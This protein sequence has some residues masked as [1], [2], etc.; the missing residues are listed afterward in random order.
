[1]LSC[2]LKYRAIITDYILFNFLELTDKA[3]RDEYIFAPDWEHIVHNLNPPNDT[4]DFLSDKVVAYKRYK[5]YFHRDVLIVEEASDD[6][7]RTFFKNNPVFF[8]KRSWSYSGYDVVKMRVEDQPVAALIRR[9]R[10]EKFDLLEAEIVQHPKMDTICPTACHSIRV[11]TFKR[12]DKMLIMPVTARV[13][14]FDDI[15]RITT[16][17]SVGSI[18]VDENGYL[19]SDAIIND[20]VFDY[21]EP[22]HFAVHPLT[23]VPISDGSFQLPDYQA[24][25]DMVTELVEN[26]DEYGH[27]GWDIALAESGPCV[28]EA[29]PWGIY[30]FYEYYDHVKRLPK[31]IRPMLEDFFECKLEDLPIR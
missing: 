1:M 2:K 16:G 17:Q 27:I 14:L 3:I 20:T 12:G 24:M 21:D 7:M 13:A 26:E 8:G 22:T 28:I 5:D 31:R 11:T 15:D 19:V 30:E 23:G 6:D 18:C 4:P 29:N 10:N 25:M 9:V